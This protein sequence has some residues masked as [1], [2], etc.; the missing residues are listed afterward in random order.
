LFYA[1]K[2]DQVH[3]HMVV[4]LNPKVPD[5]NKSIYG[6]GENCGPYLKEMAQNLVKANADFVVCACNTAHFYRK[7]I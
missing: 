4:E 2:T 7:E 5:R 3:V 1:A 6:T